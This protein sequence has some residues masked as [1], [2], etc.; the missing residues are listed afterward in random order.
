MGSKKTS[1]PGRDLFLDFPFY[2]KSGT[3]RAVKHGFALQQDGIG[4]DTQFVSFSFLACCN[5]VH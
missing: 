5:I 4:P 2:N 3:N 1:G